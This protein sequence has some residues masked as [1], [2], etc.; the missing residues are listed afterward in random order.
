MEACVMT[1]VTKKGIDL[2]RQY[3]KA[4]LAAAKTGFTQDIA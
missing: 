4:I 1:T 3:D 2:K